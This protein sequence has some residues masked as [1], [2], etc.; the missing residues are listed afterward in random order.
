MYCGASLTPMSLGYYIFHSLANT[1]VTHKTRSAL[2]SRKHHH[3]CEM[4]GF[5]LNCS[6]RMRFDK[7]VMDFTLSLTH[8]TLSVYLSLS[9]S[10]SLSVS[11]SNYRIRERWQDIER[12]GTMTGYRIREKRQVLTGR[13]QRLHVDQQGTMT[14]CRPDKKNDRISQQGTLTGYRS[15]EQ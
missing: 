11:L 7:Y 8:F 1:H 3:Y 9:F 10:L 15:R 12:Q 6:I 14:G 2:L 13:E 5:P 4:Y